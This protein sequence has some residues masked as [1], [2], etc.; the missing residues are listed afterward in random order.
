M[1]L[2]GIVMEAYP[3][4]RNSI[5]WRDFLVQFGR[6]LAS[7][8]DGDRPFKSKAEAEA[9]KPRMLTHLSAPRLSRGVF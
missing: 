5:C 6:I 1:D 8:I 4:L 3:S 9:L 7:A 2:P